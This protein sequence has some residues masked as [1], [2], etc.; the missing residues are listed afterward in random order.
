MHRR[1]RAPCLHLSDS[2]RVDLDGVAP[3]VRNGDLGP[4]AREAS[5]FSLLLGR[6]DSHRLLLPRGGDEVL[7]RPGQR[8][9]PLNLAFRTLLQ[10]VASLR[11]HPHLVVLPVLRLRRQ[12]SLLER[13]KH[14]LEEVLGLD[15]L[16]P[17]V[18]AEGVLRLRPCRTA[19][20]HWRVRARVIPAAMLLRL[21]VALPDLD[22]L[23]PLA[24]QMLLRRWGRRGGRL[25]RGEPVRLCVDQLH[26]RALGRLA[27]LD[28]HVAATFEPAKP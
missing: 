23:R 22:L 14:L 13:L 11:P 18:R 3:L 28:A 12:T 21:E 4:P 5:A 15:L 17:L 7:E 9:V 26:A 2:H 8:R 16:P 19:P 1:E 27:R 10:Q 6:S 20:Q 25:L 24:P